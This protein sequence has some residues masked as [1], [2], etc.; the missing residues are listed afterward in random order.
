MSFITYYSIVPHLPV[1]A[2]ISLSYQDQKDQLFIGPHVRLAGYPG[3]AFIETELLAI[4]FAE[5]IVSRFQKR[6]GNETKL[7]VVKFEDAESTKLMNRIQ[8]DTDIVRKRL[9]TANFI[10]NKS[11]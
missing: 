8:S 7:S 1:R 10:S 9:A 5:A 3:K 11:P 6:Y 4:S 2:P